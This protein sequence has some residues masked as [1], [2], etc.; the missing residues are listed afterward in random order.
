MRKY[1]K[2]L[3]LFRTALLFIL[4][5]TALTASASA[6]FKPVSAA[7]LKNAL[8]KYRAM[9]HLQVAFKQKKFLKDMDM[10]LESRGDLDIEPP[11]RVVYRITEPAKMTVTLTPQEIK[12]ESGSGADRSVQTI[13][14]GSIPGESEKRSLQAMVTWLKLDPDGLDRD[15]RVGKDPS[16]RFRFDPRV[17]EQSPFQNLEM[18]LSSEGH[19]KQLVMQEKSGD[20]IEFFF[21]KPKVKSQHP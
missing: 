1:R 14:T 13:K 21:E 3:P 11:S 16:G 8:A 12:I 4:L 19:L 5:A 2:A 10:A 17:P 9:T 20:R 6:E 15:Y 7:E 18:Q